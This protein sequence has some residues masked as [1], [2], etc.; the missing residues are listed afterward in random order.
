M[1]D[2]VRSWGGPASD[3]LDRTL[4]SWEKTYTADTDIG[5]YPH[6]LLARPLTVLA[7]ASERWPHVRATLEA[8]LDRRPELAV[9]P[10]QH[11]AATLALD[12][13]FPLLLRI[14][15]ALQVFTPFGTNVELQHDETKILE[16]VCLADTFPALPVEDRSQ[17][18][19]R[20]GQLLGESGRRSEAAPYTRQASE[21][22]IEIGHIRLSETQFLFPT[23]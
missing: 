11:V 12:L 15:D 20:L 10:G 5:T 19:A 3:H 18:L 17:L 21:L 14:A 1:R 22:L 16:A 2:Y 6:V 23:P 4:L 8:E 9:L 7:A 13:P